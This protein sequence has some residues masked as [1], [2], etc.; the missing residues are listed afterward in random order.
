M[1]LISYE[2]AEPGVQRSEPGVQRS[3]GAAGSKFGICHVDLLI[4]QGSF[5][6]LFV[7]LKRVTVQ[8]SNPLVDFCA[9]LLTFVLD[10]TNVP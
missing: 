4:F 1:P 8:E 2:P 7:D 3:A 10:S 5:Q 9:C 6:N